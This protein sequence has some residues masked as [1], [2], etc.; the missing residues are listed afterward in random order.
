[1]TLET[2]RVLLR[3]LTLDDAAALNEF[4]CDPRVNRYLP[5]DPHSR[6]ETRAY[7]EADLRQQSDNPRRTY[8]LALTVRGAPRL[9]G[10]CGLGINRLEHGE[11]SVWYVLHPAAWGRGHALEAASAMVDFAFGPLGLHRVWADCDP[12]NTASRRVAERLGM[13]L[14]GLLRENYRLKGEWCSTALYAILEPEWT[15]R[16]RGSPARA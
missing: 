16:R 7:I 3:D 8:D 9:I 5:Y 6:D 14:E 11:A 15:A 2:E 12:R 4:E 13:T 1:M 10:R